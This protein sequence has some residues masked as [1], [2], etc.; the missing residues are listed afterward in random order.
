MDPVERYLSELRDQHLSG[1]AVAE[2]SGYPMLRAVLDDLG[3]GLKPKVRC[4]THLKSQGA[5]IPDGGLFTLDQFPQR[6]ESPRQGQLPNVGAL[7]VKA[8][9]EELGITVPVANLLEILEVQERQ[10]RAG[11]RR[12]AHVSAWAPADFVDVPSGLQGGSSDR[13][14]SSTGIPSCEHRLRT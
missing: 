13:P 9:F 7:E 1:S 14:K 3:K 11:L 10:R 6:A 4:I 12:G 5:G 2:T 8:G